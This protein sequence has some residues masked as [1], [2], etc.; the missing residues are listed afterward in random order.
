[1]CGDCFRLCTKMDVHS[2]GERAQTLKELV[3]AFLQCPLQEGE[4][5][6]EVS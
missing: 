6:V 1:M 4:E 5:N 2:M 3:A